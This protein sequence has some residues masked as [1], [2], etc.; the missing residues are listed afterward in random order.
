[1]SDAPS[2]LLTVDGAIATVT[3]NRPEKRNAL[4]PADFEAFAA[5]LAE[6]HAAPGLRALIVT[7]AGEKAFCSGAD[8]GAVGGEH[9]ADNPLTA[10]SDGLEQFPWPTI[11][12]LNGGAYGGGM[13]IALSCDFR[14]GVEGIVAMI[15]P[16]RIGIHYEAAGIDR[17][18][19]LMGLQATRRLFLG[20]ETFDTETLRATGFLD[21]AVAREALMDEARA[22]AERLAGHAPLAMTGMKRTIHELST[23]TLDAEAARARIDEAWASEDLREGLAAAREKRPPVFKGQ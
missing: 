22:L 3:I 14:V 2:I 10:L 23:G 12:A 11:C 9:F 17:A 7:G 5:A 6:A 4:R 20:A 15:P 18:L 16:A 19:R 21:K 1:M 13:E 8:L